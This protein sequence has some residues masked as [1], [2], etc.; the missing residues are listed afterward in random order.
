MVNPA[1]ASSGRGLFALKLPALNA[2]GV[3]ENRAWGK[4]PLLNSYETK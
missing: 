3:Y 1:M 4:H 2:G